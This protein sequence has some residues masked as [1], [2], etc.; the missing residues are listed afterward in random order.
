MKSK[1]MLIKNT[2]GNTK[3]DSYVEKTLNKLI[4]RG[5]DDKQI[6][7]ALFHKFIIADRKLV[8]ETIKTAREEI[9]RG[10]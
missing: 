10:E 4:R 1:R 2:K 3:F 7:N 6:M 5:L 8:L 9:E